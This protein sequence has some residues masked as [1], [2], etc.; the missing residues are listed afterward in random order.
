MRIITDMIP[1]TEIRTAADRLA[2]SVH[3]TPQ[4]P[5]H[6]IG[7]RAGVALSLKCEL[8]QKTGSF[9]ARGALSKVL[10]LSPEARA[11][12]L[13]TV[14]AG[15]H[16]AAI[17]WA[18]RQF[19]LPSVVVMLTNASTSKVELVRAYGGE[20]VFH[21]DRATIFDK[22]H[23]IERERGMVFVHSSNDPAVLAGSA[24]LGLEIIEDV[25]DVE[26]VVV[27]VGGGGLLGGVASAIKQVAPRVRV[28]AVE[29]AEGPAL[30]PSLAAGEPVLSPRPPNTLAD[31]MTPP[32]VGALPLAI[33]KEVVDEVVGVTEREIVEAIGLLATHAKLCVEGAGAAATAAVVAKK[34]KMPAGARVVAIVSGG[35][36]DLQQLLRAIT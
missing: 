27:P 15:N 29:L 20:V 33:A 7:E 2:K 17:A 11:G 34:L 31:G 24:T 21:D 3:R 6:T 4:L 5:A 23:E 36:V 25:P 13:C 22:L 10:S 35:N 19:G 30:A 8:F 16:G 1:L 12:G 9:K 14:S 28:V 26:I 32:F 18:A